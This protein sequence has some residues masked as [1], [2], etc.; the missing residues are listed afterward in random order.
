[1]RYPTVQNIDK[2]IV[3]SCCFL[4]KPSN[5]YRIV[6][7]ITSKCCFNC[8]FCFLD[9]KY[10]D[11]TTKR[12]YQLFYKIKNSLIKIDEILLAG[13]EVFMRDDLKEIIRNITNNDINISISSN[14][15]FFKKIKG[16]L[17]F[18][19]SIRAVNLSMY[20]F[21]PK[22]NSQIYEISR[23]N[24]NKKIEKSINYLLDAGID[25][26]VNIPLMKKNSK[27]I[28]K[29]IEY[30][31]SLGIKRISLIPLLPVGK[32]E[33]VKNGYKN[34]LDL[35]DTDFLYTILDLSNTYNLEITP[36]RIRLLKSQKK[37]E[38]CNAGI[39]L[40]SILPNGM[41]TPCNLLHYSK[42]NIY[43]NYSFFGED[44][45][46]FYNLKLIKDFF[47][48]DSMKTKKILSPSSK[49]PKEF[50]GGCRAVILAER[51]KDIENI[52]FER[53]YN[54]KINVREKWITKMA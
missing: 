15:T 12:I 30:V 29:T 20:S 42:S 8:N 40:I 21:N 32:T 33:F 31:A 17:C 23:G 4:Y 3:K 46:I 34:I 53:F 45:D 37:L 44:Q 19:D 22:I 14:G 51:G 6:W 36:I 38:M 26:K 24:P 5:G 27:N 43:N 11:L 2:N 35:S 52:P 47:I 39:K 1:M 18:R 9:S 48:N 13:R 49:F 41:I 54:E 7:E 10:Q 50:G 16:I 28:K 25:T